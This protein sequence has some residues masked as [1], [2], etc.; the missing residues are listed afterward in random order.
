MSTY[1][2]KV[3]ITGCSDGGMGAALAIA[4]HEAGLDVYATA[5]DTRKM[6]KLASMG[7]NTL[8]MDVQSESSIATC[9]AQMS[10]LDILVNNAGALNR[11]PIVD[12]TLSDAKELFDLNVWSYIAITQAFL[13]LLLE[14]PNGM[15]V[16]HTSTQ[17][18]V[19]LP[20]SG[21]YG[22]S[23][24]AM[25]MITQTLRLELQPFYIRVVEMRTGYVQTKLVRNFQERRKLPL[26]DGSIYSAAKD[27]LEKSDKQDEGKGHNAEEWARS[28]TIQLLKNNPAPIIW[29][30]GASGMARLWHWFPL[31]L[32]DY[33]VKRMTGLD[34]IQRLI[35][36]HRPRSKS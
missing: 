16:N 4:F 3:L 22:A 24:A 14:S 12:T 19:V 34:V 11:M 35:Q 33:V 27:M 21:I 6:R 17:V 9:V 1:V 15:V 2:Q 23:K 18:D 13:P 7:I 29:S 30:G 20:F 10:S 25:G 32:C 28:M 8:A 36:N 31:R 5:R 26:P